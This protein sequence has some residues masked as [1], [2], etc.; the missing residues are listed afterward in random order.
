MD[1]GARTPAAEAMEETV[2][3]AMIPAPTMRSKKKRPVPRGEKG[4]DLARS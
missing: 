1:R 3:G 2:K 4:H